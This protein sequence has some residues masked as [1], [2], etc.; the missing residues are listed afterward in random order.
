MIYRFHHQRDFF[1]AVLP[2]SREIGIVKLDLKKI[3]H[4]LCLQPK[5][6]LKI[7]EEIVPRVVTKRVE[8]RKKWLETNIRKIK[9]PPGNVDEY[10]KQIQ[11][12]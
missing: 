10:V 8:Q 5:N 7:L 3:K 6:C 2:T 9:S 11:D 1:D 4:K 12:H